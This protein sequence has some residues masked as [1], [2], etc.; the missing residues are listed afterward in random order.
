MDKQYCV[1]LTE[2]YRAVTIIPHAEV[3]LGVILLSWPAWNMNWGFCGVQLRGA[4]AGW[5]CHKPPQNAV[6]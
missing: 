3:F 5:W 6:A 2:A 4:V 1:L